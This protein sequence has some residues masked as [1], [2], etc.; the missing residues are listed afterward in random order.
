MIHCVTFPAWHKL[1]CGLCSS[2]NADALCAKW[3]ICG[4]TKN[5]F[6]VSEKE[7]PVSHME[8]ESIC[9][10][11]VPTGILPQIFQTFIT[12]RLL[13]DHTIH[14]E[15]L[16]QCK[17]YIKTYK[18]SVWFVQFIFCANHFYPKQIFYIVITWVKFMSLALFILYSRIFTYSL[19][20]P[21]ML[22]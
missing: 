17:W 15:T 12:E 6:C 22:F 9:F 7:V 21:I 5:V 14:G 13:L 4:Q 18:N 19:K 8:T 11:P 10:C 16:V 2:S 3:V 1:T 20:C